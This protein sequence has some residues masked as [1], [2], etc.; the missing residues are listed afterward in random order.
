MWKFIV[1]ILTLTPILWQ[2]HCKKQKT[3]KQ[4]HKCINP[5]NTEIHPS[6]P[7][8]KICF[9]GNH[10]NIAYQLGVASAFK[11]FLDF[12]EIQ[13]YGSSFGSIISTALHLELSLDELFY[14]LKTTMNQYRGIFFIWKFHKLYSN[15]I[16]TY[17]NRVGYPPPSY[18]FTALSL[19][20]S[21]WMEISP[22]DY[23]NIL[24]YTYL[25]PFP[26]CIPKSVNDN[27]IIINKWKHR[28]TFQM[29]ISMDDTSIIPPP[30]SFHYKNL[31]QSGSI[32]EL[33]TIG[34]LKAHIV[35]HTQSFWIPYF[36]RPPQHHNIM[37]CKQFIEE[38]DTLM[39]RII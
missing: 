37:K 28:E 35:L 15:F 12:D 36:K 30:I 2:L 17:C 31:Y 11:E 10:W 6:P 18:V 8:L 39:E 21:K 25:L 27:G 5:S 19:T 34:Y 7:P 23:K 1:S 20:K 22:P 3:Q 4:H 24:K 32:E 9:H 29:E 33:F 14:F 26:N 16:D 38:I 13:F